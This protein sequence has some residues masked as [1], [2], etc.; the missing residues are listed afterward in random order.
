MSL[1]QIGKKPIAIA[2]SQ[3]TRIGVTAPNQLIKDRANAQAI[4]AS[5]QSTYRLKVAAKNF[6]RLEDLPGIPIKDERF[7]CEAFVAEGGEFLDQ[8][9]WDWGSENL[10]AVKA[11][12]K[13]KLDSA[14]NVG[15]CVRSVMDYWYKKAELIKVLGLSELRDRTH[16][17]EDKKLLEAYQRCVDNREEIRLYF[18]LEVSPNESP[19]RTI[20]KLLRKL[21]G[22][23]VEQ[24]A[25]VGPN[26]Q[27]L[28][29]Y[30]V[31]DSR[32]QTREDICQALEIRAS[33]VVSE[34]IY[35]DS[36]NQYSPDYQLEY[37]S[38]SDVVLFPELERAEKPISHCY[39][40]PDGI[41]QRK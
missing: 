28:R 11:L 41:E 24:I 18:D 29:V 27:Q 1:S 6:L 33:K 40:S 32:Q 17:R 23:D 7:Y 19:V 15:E 39:H 30:Q 37:S 10:E 5:S 20:N 16:T 9:K 38:Q 36:N 4:L 35:I 26:G 34:K 12:E 14:I 21:H 25:A 3:E 8:V 22:F 2:C 31:T 13:E